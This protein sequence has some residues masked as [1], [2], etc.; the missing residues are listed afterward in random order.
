MSHWH[1]APTVENRAQPH[2][3]AYRQ[4]EPCFSSRLHRMTLASGILP[5]HIW[6]SVLG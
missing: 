1:S 2:A 4:S 6:I 3:K 5:V